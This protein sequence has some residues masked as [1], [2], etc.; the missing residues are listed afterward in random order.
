MPVAAPAAVEV[1]VGPTPIVKGD[2]R[3]VGDITVINEKLA[4][5][6][7]VQSAAPYGVPRGALVDLA[8]V[9]DGRIGRDRV[10]FADFIPDHWSAWQNTY[11]HVDIL[12]R[13]PQRAVIRTVRDWGR[14]VITTVYTL[15]ADSDHVEIRATMLNTDTVPTAVLLSGLTLWPGSGYLFGVPGMQDV[16]EG[17]VD[18]PIG[19]RV[20]AYDADWGRGPACRLFRSRRR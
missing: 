3:A 4:F 20:V 7:A 15:A 5:A 19:R 17:R 14:V 9:S 8:P 12:E 13:G 10:V 6:L 16:A 18:A 11:Q 1:R 2:A